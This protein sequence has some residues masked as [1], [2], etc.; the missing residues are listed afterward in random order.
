MKRKEGR[1]EPYMVFAEIQFQVSLRTGGYESKATLGG[2]IDQEI[3]ES[4]LV[5]GSQNLS[6]VW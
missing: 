5:H 4:L 3:R 1:R 2:A 6:L